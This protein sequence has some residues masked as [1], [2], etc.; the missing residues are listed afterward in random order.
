MSHRGTLGTIHW[1]MIQGFVSNLQGQVTI[2][3]LHLF[4]SP[5]AA[6]AVRRPENLR[7]KPHFCHFFRESILDGSLKDSSYSCCLS[8]AK[9]SCGLVFQEI[10]SIILKPLSMARRVVLKAKPQLSKSESGGKR[11]PCS[12]IYLVIVCQVVLSNKHQTGPQ[13]RWNLKLS[14][15]PKNR[16]FPEKEQKKRGQSSRYSCHRGCH[17]CADPCGPLQR[18]SPGNGVS[19]IIPV[20]W[21]YVSSISVN[22]NILK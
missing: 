17:Q 18:P 7:G 9:M 16:R 12:H 19:L 11:W 13:R 8:S 22:S 2:A 10:S 3:S 20:N 4:P 1:K 6:E 14:N 21:W 5:A 15:V